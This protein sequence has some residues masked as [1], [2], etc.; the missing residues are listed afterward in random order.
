MPDILN[1][2]LLSITQLFLIVIFCAG[3]IIPATSFLSLKL[4]AQ[5]EKISD[6]EKKSLFTHLNNEP[7]KDLMNQKIHLELKATDDK[8]LQHLK[9]INKEIDKLVIHSNNRKIHLK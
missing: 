3:L 8:I 2:K 4:L 9:Y 6:S 7:K 5:S 1:K